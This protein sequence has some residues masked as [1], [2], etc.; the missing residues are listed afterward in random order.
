MRVLKHLLLSL[1]AIGGL[2]SVPASATTLTI[3]IVSEPG[4]TPGRMLFNGNGGVGSTIQFPNGSD[5]YDFVVAGSSD[6]ALIGLKGNITGSFSIGAISA[7]GP[8]QFAPVSNTGTFSIF[9]GAN[10]L[11]A[12]LQLLSIGTLGT[13]V[14]LNLNGDPNLSNFAYTGGNASL[15]ALSGVNDASLVLSGQFSHPTSLLSLTVNKAVNSAVYSG[16]LQATV[17]EASSYL[18]LAAGVMAAGFSMR[19]RRLQ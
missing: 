11:T 4:I 12:D 10:T 17:P 6:T 3:D 15:L 1:L 2:A 19:N 14:G 16:T 7:V 5:G 8:A 18:F 13:S 9:D